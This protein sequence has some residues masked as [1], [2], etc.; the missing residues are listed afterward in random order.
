MAGE[1]VDLA[2]KL[3]YK[4]LSERSLVEVNDVLNDIVAEGI[5]YQAQSIFGDSRDQPH[6]L[7]TRGVVYAP[8]KDTAAVTMGAHIDATIADSTEN[9][10]GI[11]GRQLV[12]AFLDHVVAI[13]VLDKIDNLVLQCA[14]DNLN[15]SRGIDELDHLLQSAR[16]MLV[17]GNADHISS[18]VLDQDRAFLVVTKLQEFLAQVVAKR[19]SHQL[20][21][22][23]VGLQ[24]NHV[25]LVRYTV[26]KLLL[27]VSA[28]VLVLAEVVDATNNLLEGEVVK[29]AH[30]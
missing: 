22:V 5:L 8:L 27:K 13:E 1:H 11:G 14:N 23:R 9:K 30:S 28:T 18:G 17:E 7:F 26:F 6:L 2:A 10:L 29:A 4:R 21:N 16:A 25:H 15:L 24:P 3:A 20:D 19:I 12:Q